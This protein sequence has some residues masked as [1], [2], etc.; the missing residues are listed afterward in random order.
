VART[1][2]TTSFEG[3]DLDVLRE[4][5]GITIAQ[6]HEVHFVDVLHAALEVAARH[7]DEVLER[8]H[9]QGRSS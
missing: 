4:L 5:R 8:L 1:R 6:G 3:A 7:R 9:V 2:L